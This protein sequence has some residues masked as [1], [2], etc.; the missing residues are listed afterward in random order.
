MQLS[1]NPY[2]YLFV[3]LVSAILKLARAIFK[4]ARAIFKLRQL[5]QSMVRYSDDGNEDCRVRDFWVTH[6]KDSD[7][8]NCAEEI[9]CS[10][11]LISSAIF[12]EPYLFGFRSKGQARIR[13][14]DIQAFARYVFEAGKLHSVGSRKPLVQK[15]IEHCN[16]VARYP[17]C[18]T[19]PVSGPVDKSSG[20]LA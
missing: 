20:S 19:E 9:L 17:K 1:S 14:K 2:L 12:A 10:R 11:L 5:A 15:M 13:S 6:M 4:L 7:L 16:S 18:P 3:F 8:R